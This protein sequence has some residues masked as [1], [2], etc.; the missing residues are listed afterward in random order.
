MRAASQRS[1][2]EVLPLQSHVGQSPDARAS[3]RT[4]RVSALQVELLGHA[5]KEA[6]RLTFHVERKRA[7]TPRRGGT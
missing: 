5:A 2:L 7:R 4:E 3:E 1:R 6:R